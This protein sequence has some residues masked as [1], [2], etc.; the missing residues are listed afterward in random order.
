LAPGP[1]GLLETTFAEHRTE[2]VAEILLTPG[3]A[4]AGFGFG[5]FSI[6]RSARALLGIALMDPPIASLHGWSLADWRFQIT[7]GL[8]NRES[9]WSGM[10][11]PR[12]QK[13]RNWT[14]AELRIA[15]VPIY[16]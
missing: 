2:Q 4:A 12:R 8:K 6:G 9:V 1:A 10:I 14:V 5:I 7:R 15:W 16:A 3:I 11:A 13:F